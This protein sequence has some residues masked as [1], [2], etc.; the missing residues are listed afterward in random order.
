MSFDAEFIIGMEVKMPTN[1]TTTLIAA[2]I[3]IAS[4]TVSAFAGPLQ[5]RVDAGETIRIG[6]ANIPLWAY[7]DDSGKADGFTNDIAIQT[8]ANMGLTNKAA[9]RFREMSTVRS[10]FTLG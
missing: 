3:A 5:D 7:P 9:R 1:F 8:L 10:T 4:S 2:S 6:F